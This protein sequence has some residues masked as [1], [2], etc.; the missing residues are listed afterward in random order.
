M[1]TLPASEPPTV[2]LYVREQYRDVAKAL[3]LWAE[4]PRA[5]HNG[6]IALR[7]RGGGRLLLADRRKC[8]YLSDGERVRPPGGMLQL[9]APAG[10]SCDTACAAAGARCDAPALEWGNT[11]EAMA[12][13]FKCE[14]GCGHQVGPELPAYASAPDLDTHRQCL[15][16]DIAVST[17]SAN[18]RKTSRLCTCVGADGGGGPPRHG[19]TRKLVRT[20]EETR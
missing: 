1:A 3:G 15:I 20:R 18:F 12:R 4:H 14:A 8:P 17:C 11:C 6:T 2:L 16:S 7:T 19:A 5:T 9:A 13:H 10:T